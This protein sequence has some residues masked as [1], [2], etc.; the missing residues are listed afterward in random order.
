MWSFRTHTTTVLIFLNLLT[1]TFFLLI[2]VF[3]DLPFKV[4]PH[5]THFSYSRMMSI[6][7]RTY[8]SGS[9]VWVK[10]LFRVRPLTM[11]QVRPNFKYKC[12]NKHDWDAE[13]RI[14]LVVIQN[15]ECP[16]LVPLN[17]EIQLIGLIRNDLIFFNTISRRV[18]PNFQILLKIIPHIFINTTELLLESRLA[19]YN[20]L[21]LGR[22]IWPS[23]GEEIES[24]YRRKV[25]LAIQEIRDAFQTW[26]CSCPED[27]CQNSRDCV[28]SLWWPL[29]ILG[30]IGPL[31]TKRAKVRRR[32]K[33]NTRYWGQRS[34]EKDLGRALQ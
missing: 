6:R 4:S 32:Q 19:S 18:E 5:S 12:R 30:S 13:K 9:A 23:C 17:E 28:G 21:V 34:I 24:E 15:R 3:S 27:W 31:A 29:A 11:T 8:S 14:I 25:P 33:F 16:R 1:C 10:I 7:R 20:V 26:K 2:F 22:A